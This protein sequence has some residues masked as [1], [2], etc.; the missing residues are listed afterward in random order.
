M[1]SLKE[2]LQRAKATA[3]KRWT[4]TKKMASDAVDEVSDAVVLDTKGKKKTLKDLPGDLKKIKKEADQRTWVS[5]WSR[6]K[7]PLKRLWAFVRS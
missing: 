6:S 4:E 7:N 3:S 5:K 1:G 2:I